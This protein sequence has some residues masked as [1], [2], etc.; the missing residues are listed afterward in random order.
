LQKPLLERALPYS[1]LAVA[2][3]FLTKFGQER[4]IEHMKLQ[5][6]VYF[7]HGWWLA[8]NT[9]SLL[10][11]RPQ[12][13]KHGPVFKTLYHTLKTFGHQ[14]ISQP[15]L[16]YPAEPVQVVS[17]DNVVPSYIDFVW[18]RYGRLS[19][20]ALSG[21][22]HQPGGAWSKLAAEHNYRVPSDLEIPDEYV[23]EE[24]LKLYNEEFAKSGNSASQ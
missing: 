19:S 24:F 11:E 21:M 20:F 5:K 1:S 2:N 4:G 8:I 18:E 23:R 15:Q 10:T 22:T 7:T 3:T 17:G 6:L 16:R 9:H 12:V 13:W 14:P